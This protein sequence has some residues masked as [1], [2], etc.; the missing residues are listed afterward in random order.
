VRLD[1]S[2]VEDFRQ[3]ALHTFDDSAGKFVAGKEPAFHDL[4]IRFG[5]SRPFPLSDNE[6][7]D[8]VA[9]QRGKIRENPVQLRAPLH[10]DAGLL[11]KLARKSCLSC[12]PP[13]DATAREVPAGPIAVANQQDAIVIVDDD[14]LRP[15]RGAPR[16]SPIGCNKTEGN[17]ADHGPLIVSGRSHDELRRFSQGAKT[18]VRPLHASYAT[19]NG[20]C[21]FVSALN[22]PKA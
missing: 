10:D 7:R 4:A 15:Q 14:S 16:Q 3:P 9:R 22:R 8:V 1:R 6:H 21:F 13:F 11:E 5:N 18:P 12:F 2:A 17:F 19:K 20:R